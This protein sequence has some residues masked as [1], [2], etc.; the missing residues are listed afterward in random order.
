MAGNSHVCFKL[1]R[2]QPFSSCPLIMLLMYLHA[3]RMHYKFKQGCQQEVAAAFRKNDWHAALSSL[4]LQQDI[5]LPM[6]LPGTLASQQEQLIRIRCN[7]GAS[8][9]SLPAED[10]V[11]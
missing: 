4:Q 6:A 11:A 7:A 2:V 1:M 3:G 9:S 10:T 5:A 8:V